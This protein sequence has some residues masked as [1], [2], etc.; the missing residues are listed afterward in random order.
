MKSPFSLYLSFFF[1][2]SFSQFSFGQDSLLTD[3]Y[4]E[5]T[6][7]NLSRLINK[8]YVSA[9]VAKTTE[10]HVM[11]QLKAGH[12]EPFQ[13]EET[14]AAALTESVQEINSD[15]HMRI[16]VKTPFEA[17]K[18]TPER[19][20][21]EKVHQRNKSRSS[22]SGL[23]KVEILDGNV[24]YLDL[25]SFDRLESGKTVTDSYMNLLAQSDA[26]IIDLS[27]NGGGFPRMVQYLCSYFFDE[28][29][30]LNS[31]YYRDRNDTLEFWTL[32]KVGGIK[33]P[34]V[35]LYVITSD[36]T[37][38]G[39]EE[40]SYNMQTQKRATLVGQTTRGG[41]NP[42]R[43]FNLSENLEV[44]VPI[45]K[46]IN[47]ITKTNWESVGVI[48]EIK[49][50]VDDA[51]I[52]AYELAKVAAKKNRD[53]KKEA[54]SKLYLNLIDQLNL[55]SKVDSEHEIMAGLLACKDA[56]L[57][58][59]HEINMLGYSYIM[60]HN[61]PVTAEVVFKANTMLYP[62]SFNVYDSYGEVL[63]QMGKR[64][65]SIE[66]YQKSI[67]LNSNNENGIN[68]L[69]EL[70]AYEAALEP[71]DIYFLKTDSTWRKEPFIFPLRFARD[72][73]YV[74]VE[75]ARFPI[76]WEDV[77]S[78][79]FWSYSFAWKVNSDG[80]ISLKELENNLKKYF[81]GL[82]HVADRMKDNNGELNIQETNVVL[83]EKGNTE[84]HTSYVGKI[85]TFDGFSAKEMMTL[86]VEV[87]NY[88]CNEKRESVIHF[89]F[90]P[91]EFGHEVWHHLKEVKLPKKVCN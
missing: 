90:S 28:K 29:V 23:N 48:P 70:D 52:K 88:F 56:G 37:F 63:L 46:A 40:F 1:C 44:F 35:P 16:M 65:Q 78:P 62:H 50:K 54:L 82:M 49:T 10:E 18:N 84:S 45:G 34:D 83:V 14:F 80:P 30:H 12:F 39:A 74:G 47:P 11:T 25:R 72:I 41:A 9:D 76:G 17:P 61:N 42:G 51:Y 32:D 89:R 85:S 3:S 53:K 22:N 71:E 26:I 27:K 55:Y 20:I 81:D 75:D 68:V 36:Q 2:I 43:I 86:H 87:D 66:N 13:N 57:L 59:E 91:K 24:G 21:E 19:I 64:E 4:K 60:D 6:I 67:S 77:D 79:N 5:Q 33:M 69:K 8:F 31:L 7:A 38:S 15:K 73:P 58:D